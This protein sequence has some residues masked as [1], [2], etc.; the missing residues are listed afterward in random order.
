MTEAQ[1][2]ELVLYYAGAMIILAVIL[3]R[4]MLNTGRRS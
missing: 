1:L 3:I 4:Q 2:I